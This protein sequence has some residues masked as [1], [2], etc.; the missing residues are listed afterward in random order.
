[1]RLRG[2]SA[3]RNAALA[4]AAALCAGASGEAVAAALAAFQPPHRR[5]EIVHR[6][7]FTVLDDTVGHPESVSALFAVVRLM[8][9]RRLHIAFAI[10]GRRGAAIN[11]HLAQALA[12]QVARLPVATLA[13][14]SSVEATDERNRVGAAERAAFVEALQTARIAFDEVD[15]LDDA[16]GRVL[17]RAGPHDLVLLL[18]AQGMDS[19]ASV[20]RAWLGAR[21]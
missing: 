1:M 7:G 13:I 16:V 15:R 2:P 17:E 20:A 3:L 14:T 12:I 21:A 6:G 5:M 18:G 4:A 19:G 9:P 8:R 10:R 11:R